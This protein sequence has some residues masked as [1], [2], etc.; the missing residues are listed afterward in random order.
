MLQKKSFG[1]IFPLELIA[2]IFIIL[3]VATADFS[4]ST[5]INILM[6]AIIFFASYLTNLIKAKITGTGIGGTVLVAIIIPLLSLAIAYI[7]FLI[8]P[9]LNFWL[10]AGLGLLSVFINELLKQLKQSVN[11]VQTNAETKLIG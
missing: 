7:G 5:I 3:Q 11:G 9:G 2:L 6:P 1:F 8:V 4:L 10:S